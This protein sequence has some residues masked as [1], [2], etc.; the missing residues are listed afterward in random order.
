MSDNNGQTTWAVVGGGLLGMTVA[1]TLAR[2]GCPV[3]LFEAAPSCGG[4][5]SA[6]RI[7]DIT[8]DRHYHVTLYSDG[9]VRSLLGEL[10]LDSAMQWRKTKTSFYHDGK[11]HPFSSALDYL[12]FP[13]LGPI[14][15][16]RL[17][18]TI[19][20]ASRLT[21]WRSLEHQTVEE[22]LT[23]L[24]GTGV[25][26]KIWKPLLQAK[27]GESYTNT[28]ATFL[29]ATIQR[30]YAARRSGL[31]EELFGYLPGGYARLLT[32][33]E[34]A[35][36][37]NNV[38]ICLNARTQSVC[39]LGESGLT[40]TL[41]HG[42]TMSFDRVIVTAPG[43]IASSLCPDLTSEEQ[44]RL[45]AP[46]YLG[47][48]CASVLLRAP[49]T[50]YYITNIL[51]RGIPFTGL[52]E[53]SALVD[54]AEIGAHGLLYIPRYLPPD[55]PDFSRTDADLETEMMAALRRMHPSI[56]G[57]DVLDFKIS[58]ARHVF[59]RPTLGFSQRV[60]PVD[61]SVPG[62]SFVNSTQILNGTLNANETIALGRRE[63]L[64]IHAL[65]Q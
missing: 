1:Y 59:P 19:L 16:A 27:L 7:G 29:W 63:A 46:P 4:L 20:H 23:S 54:P 37:R 24:S 33:F 32:E 35:L 5:A 30:M 12:R 28:S 18:Y 42:R 60:P 6:W 53:M 21:D 56:S 62:L 22:W 41:S 55:H 17:G 48:I 65:V 43:P 9:E 34:A 49:L 11:L 3:T 50:P 64:R 36:R 44:S 31:K 25:F 15:K 61:S 40:V 38:H 45:A 58:R 2:A 10:G 39:K 51:D 47:I 52:I 13:L 57:H 26:Q 8:W 14:E